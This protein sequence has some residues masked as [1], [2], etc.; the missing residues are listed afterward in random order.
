[1]V[2]HAVTERRG[3]RD[4]SRDRRADPVV[5]CVNGH[6]S[7]DGAID[8]G[9]VARPISTPYHCTIPFQKQQPANDNACHVS[10]LHNA[11]HT[12]ST[13]CTYALTVGPHCINDRLDGSFCLF[14]KS[15]Q[16][17]SVKLDAADDTKVRKKDRR[18]CAAPV[19][20]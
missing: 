5:P 16:V 13:T 19:G 7:A 4:R 20:R 8:T 6:S 12:P 3:E 11:L 14:V 10:H 18:L 1:M 15:R 2:S 9:S 17:D